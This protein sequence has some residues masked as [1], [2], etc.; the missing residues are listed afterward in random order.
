MLASEPMDPRDVVGRLASTFRDSPVP[1]IVSA[2]V[3]GSHVSGRIH[4]DSD[5]DLGVLFD[6]RLY[7]TSRQR[8][9]ARVVL[10]G[11]LARTV[12]AR[13]VDLVGLDD[14]PPT[15]VRK[16]MTQGLRV[17]CANAEADPAARRTAL[18]RAADLEPFLRRMRRIKLDAIAR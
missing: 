11:H 18:S 13:D 2:Y 15:L 17:F 12:H 8:F 1:G 16:V 6:R 4:N 14:A 10:S 5:L 3:F 9:D 7:E